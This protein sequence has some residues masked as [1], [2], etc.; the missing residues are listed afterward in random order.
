M[1]PF[2]KKT[3]NLLEGVLVFVCLFVC[4]FFV[5]QIICDLSTVYMSKAYLTKSGS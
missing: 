1:C 5:K 3:D 2:H 4:L